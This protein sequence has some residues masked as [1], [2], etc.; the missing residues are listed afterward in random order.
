MIVGGGVLDYERCWGPHPSDA[1]IVKSCSFFSLLRFHL[2]YL[3]FAIEA[4]NFGHKN[5]PTTTKRSKHFARIL[6]N[7]LNGTTVLGVS[8]LVLVDA[9]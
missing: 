2:A 4:S 8:H 1:W 5:N 9:L 3:I 6:Q 7:F